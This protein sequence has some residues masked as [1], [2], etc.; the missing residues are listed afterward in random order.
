METAKQKAIRE[1]YG[2][3]FEK[4]NPDENGWVNYYKCKPETIGLNSW[5]I[6]RDIIEGEYRLTTLRFIEINRGWTKIE[7][8]KDYP[9][10]PNMYWVIMNGN[11]TTL[12]FDEEDGFFK[13]HLTNLKPTHYQPIINPEPPIY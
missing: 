1:A 12:C 5:D 8:E 7:S 13:E 10:E 9:K 6:D 11:I 4:C 3:N 2:E